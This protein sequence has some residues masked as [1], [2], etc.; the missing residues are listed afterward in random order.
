MYAIDKCYCLHEERQMT[1]I[2]VQLGWRGKQLGRSPTEQRQHHRVLLQQCTDTYHLACD[3]R[4][5]QAL[6]YSSTVC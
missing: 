4:P 6:T 2:I 1:N 3:C 5:P